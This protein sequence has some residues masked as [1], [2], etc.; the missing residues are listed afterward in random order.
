MY[1]EFQL[2][3]GA[4]GMAAQYTNSV[5]TRNLNAWSEQYDIAYIKKIH[6]YTVRV[7]FETDKH[8]S[9]FAMTWRPQSDKMLTYLTNYRLIE[10]MRRV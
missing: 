7:T 5:L 8:Y 3:T 4:G 10:P 6:K 9:F 2:P 1:L